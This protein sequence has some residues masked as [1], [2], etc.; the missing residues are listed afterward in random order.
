[1]AFAQEAFGLQLLALLFCA[2]LYVGKKE[3]I[4]EKR[5]RGRNIRPFLLIPLPAFLYTR[6]CCCCSF[7]VPASVRKESYGDVR[8]VSN[9]PEK[10]GNFK[11][12][13]GPNMCRSTSKRLTYYGHEF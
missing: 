11:S 8:L 13:F 12:P 7:F 1:M 3:N 5:Q 10:G 4:K 9:A 6:C 2:R